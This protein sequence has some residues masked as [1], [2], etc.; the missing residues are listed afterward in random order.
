[1]RT[2]VA[3]SIL[4]ILAACLSTAAGPVAAAQAERERCVRTADSTKSVARLWDEAILD[5]IRRDTPRPTVHARNLYHLST[6]MWDAWAAYDPTA[7][8]VFFHEKAEADDI[9]AA[10][11]RAISTAAYRILTHRYGA[12]NGAEESLAEFDALM[13][14]LCYPVDRIS[15]RGGS[16]TALGNRIAQ[17]ILRAGLRDGSNEAANYTAPEYVPANEPLIVEL[18]GTTMDDPD[19]WQPLALDVAI[20]QNGIPEPVGPQVA[21]TPHWGHVTSFAM[22]PSDIGLPL[23]PGRAPSIRGADGGAGF[24]AE[25]V[26]VIELSS[27]LDPTDRRLID[28]SPRS[29]GNNPLG[30]NDGQGYD[31]NPVTGQPYEPDYVLRGDFGRALAEFWADGPKSETPPGHWNSIANEVVDSPGFERR[32]GGV[33]DE[34]DPLEWDVKMYLA[35]NGAVHDA[36][37]VAWGAKGYYDSARPIS[38]I[39]HMGGLGQSS[40]PAGPSYHADGLPLVPGLIEVVTHESSAPGQR[41]EALAEHV[42]EIAL[43]AW[44]GNP[45]D[46]ETQASGVDWIRA[47]EWVPYQEPTFVTPAFP[48]FTSGHS[49]FSRAA[50]EVLAAMTGTPFFPGGIATWTIPEGGLSFEAGPLRPLELQ[51]A[52]YYDAADQAGLSRLYGGIHVPADDFGGRRTGAQCGIA[53]WETAQRYFDGSA[54]V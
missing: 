16:P 51:W 35:L 54:R 11:D 32:V 50:A 33:G 38:M 43:H 53:A 48:G 7:D 37:V 4:L 45:E 8:G 22:A 21:V 34:L 23:D 39:R 40:D 46:P 14:S 24:K 3:L 12:A 9:P 20:S 44:A 26:R 13:A 49:T 10:R 19:H 36:G 52:T 31:V 6:A 29:S 5:A 25:A 41:H 47:V 18:P 27:Q 17:R 42:G 30:T 15:R 28:I 2:R 1:M